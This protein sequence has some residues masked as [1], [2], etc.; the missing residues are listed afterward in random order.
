MAAAGRRRAPPQVDDPM[1]D[2][3]LDPGNPGSLGGV[4]RLARAVGVGPKATKEWL[5]S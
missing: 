3:Y 4:A 2:A 5:Q 1:A